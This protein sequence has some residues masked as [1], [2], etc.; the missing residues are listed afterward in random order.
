MVKINQTSHERQNPA[1][2][3]ALQNIRF[4][5][6][7]LDP[8]GVEV[9]TLSELRGRVPASVLQGPQRVEFFMLMVVTRGH[10]AHHVDFDRVNLTRGRAVFV[11]PGQVQEWAPSKSCDADLMLIE[12][13]SLQSRRGSCANAAM[14]LLR[15]EEWSSSFDLDRTEL[16]TCQQ[17]AA[18][19]RRE[20]APAQVT[21]VSSTLARELL[22]CALL[23]ISR[24]A[25]RSGQGLAPSSPLAQRFTAELERAVAQR[26]GVEAM[27]KKL[28]VSSS[29]LNR[30]CQ[31]RFGHSAKDTIDRRVALEA[32]RL[33]VH[34]EA[35]SVAIGEQL[36]FSE[37]TNF[38]KFFRRR[39][40]ATPEAFRRRV[41]PISGA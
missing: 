18:M 24:A 25:L 36:G 5:N 19:L 4:S 17:L 40:G 12:P 2:T 35:T 38:L 30:V 20:L 41:R 13:T 37:P 15:L 1:G 26:P 7:R 11:R 22:V 8:V 9:L 16:S 33:L 39:V 3:P 29:T 21:P 23:A 32:Q 28:G 10:G 27:A 14:G 34:T 6:K 31:A